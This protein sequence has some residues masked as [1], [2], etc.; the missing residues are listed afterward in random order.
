MAFERVKIDLVGGRAPAAFTCTRCKQG[1]DAG[2]DFLEL[3]AMGAIFGPLCLACWP[4]VPATMERIAARPGVFFN[5]ELIR[6]Q[7]TARYNEAKA[8]AN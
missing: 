6:H 2:A 7:V 1:R 5:V 3:H 8:R 4:E